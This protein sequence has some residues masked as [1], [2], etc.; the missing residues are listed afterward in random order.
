MHSQ[1]SL[2]CFNLLHLSLPELFP[3]LYFGFLCL[4]ASSV[5]NFCPDTRGWRGS[6]I[7]VHLFSYIVRRQGHCKQMSLACVCGECF[8]CV[9]TLGLPQLKVACTFWVYTAQALGCSA[10]VLSQVDPAFHALPRSKLLRFS[11]APQG[12]R[13]RWECILCPSQVQAA[14]VT[15]RLASAPSRVARA[16]YLISSPVLATRFPRCAVR[17]LS[18]ACCVSPL[19]SWSQSVTLLGDVNRS[20]SQ[21]DVVSNWGAAHSLVEDAVSGAEIAPWLLALAVARLPLCFWLALFWYWL[22]PLF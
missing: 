13:P 8:Q 3:L 14:Q 15:R 10:R 18:Q 9:T 11:G 4:Q 20:G 22:N 19:G 17:T 16:S 12:Y 21:E 2:Q 5:S 7:W 1:C 6:L